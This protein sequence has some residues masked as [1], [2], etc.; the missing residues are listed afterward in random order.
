[1][2]LPD[3]SVNQIF[4]SGPLAMPA[5]PLARVGVGYSVIAPAGVILPILELFHSVNHTLPSGPATMF[6]GSELAVGM[7]YSAMIWIGVEDCAQAIPAPA[8]T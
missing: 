3:C 1:M 4:P 5:G 2:L 8:R 6:I 7:G